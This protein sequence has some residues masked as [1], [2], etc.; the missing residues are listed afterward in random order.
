MI[1]A[2]LLNDRETEVSLVS[3]VLL[4]LPAQLDPV[5]LLAPLATMDPRYVRSSPSKEW[6][7]KF[8]IDLKGLYALLYH[9]ETFGSQHVSE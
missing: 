5:D 3:V 9:K 7:L 6:K 4:V 1:D 2:F 8:S